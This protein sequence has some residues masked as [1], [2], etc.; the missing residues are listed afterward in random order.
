MPFWIGRTFIHNRYVVFLFIMRLYS[1]KKLN[2]LWND[3]LHFR[4]IFFVQTEW[5]NESMQIIVNK[6]QLHLSR[7]ATVSVCNRCQCLPCDTMRKRKC[8]VH[9]TWIEWIIFFFCYYT[10]QLLR[11]T[12]KQFKGRQ[13]DDFKIWFSGYWPTPLKDR[14]FSR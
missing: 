13:N 8:I 10:Y 3:W 11:Q 2:V 7:C 5:K 1:F 9:H 14:L 6:F 12:N 4:F